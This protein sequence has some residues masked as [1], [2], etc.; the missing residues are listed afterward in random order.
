MSAAPAEQPGGPDVPPNQL[1]SHEAERVRVLHDVD[2]EARGV[3]ARRPPLGQLEFKGFEN[4]FDR[5]VR[6]AAGDVLHDAVDTVNFVLED[7][8]GH[9][10]VLDGDARTLHCITPIMGSRL[11]GGSLRE[12]TIR[13]CRFRRPCLEGHRWCHR[14]RRA[15]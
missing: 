8:T 2:W 10:P 14:R 12:L 13:C 7:L 9:V 5:D 15:C 1:G 6:T 11:V 3:S 4:L